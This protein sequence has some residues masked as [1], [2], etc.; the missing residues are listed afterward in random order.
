MCKVNYCTTKN[1]EGSDK[2]PAGTKCYHP[3]VYRAGDWG[4][5]Y[6]YTKPDKSMFG[7]ECQKCDPIFCT[8]KYLEG[9]DTAP[10]GTKCYHPCENVPVGWGKSYCYTNA[11]VQTVYV[12]FQFLNYHLLS[13]NCSSHAFHQVWQQ[14]AILPP[15]F[16]MQ[17]LHQIKFI[18][19]KIMK[20]N[21]AKNCHHTT[22]TVNEIK[23]TKFLIQLSQVLVVDDQHHFSDNQMKTLSLLCKS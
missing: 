9:I 13:S 14:R 20:H 5:S 12:L 1:L 23:W 22:N 8:T 3:C 17:N 21:I 19:T 4:Y 15:T 7:A 2:A 16:M 6:C 18:V 10:A 11:V